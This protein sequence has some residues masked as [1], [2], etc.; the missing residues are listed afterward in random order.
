MKSD[1]DTPDLSDAALDSH[2]ENLRSQLEGLNISLQLATAEKH[3]REQKNLNQ[4]S[5]LTSNPSTKQTNIPDT[6]TVGARVRIRNKYRGNKG[7][8][9]KI[10]FLSSRTATVEIPNE[11][12]FIKY[13]HNLELLPSVD[14]ESCET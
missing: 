1:P 9:G 12:S 8:V 14:D 4:R 13:F 11:G 3:R 6:F 5:S 10:I 2:I 7:K